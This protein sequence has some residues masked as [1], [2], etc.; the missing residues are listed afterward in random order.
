MG[1]FDFD[2]NLEQAL[3]KNLYDPPYFIK[4]FN[5]RRRW[6]LKLNCEIFMLMEC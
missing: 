6:F 1:G 5:I 3:L 2:N 4:K